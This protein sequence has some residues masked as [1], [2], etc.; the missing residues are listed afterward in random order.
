[1]F[2]QWRSRFRGVLLLAFF[3]GI[4]SPLAAQTISQQRPSPPRSELGLEIGVPRES[5]HHIRFAVS[6]G[7]R[8][9]TLIHRRSLSISD[10]QAAGDFTAIDVSAE[11]DGGAIRVRVSVIYNDLSNQ[12]WWK[13]KKEKIAGSYV[14]REGE[15]VWPTELAQ[16][17]IEPFEMK[18]ISAGPIVFKPGEGP[19]IIN[20]STALE[21][22]RLE[23]HLDS[24]LISLKNISSK[25]VVA[26]TISTGRGGGVSTSSGGRGDPVI[27]AGATTRET[28]LYGPNVELEGITISNVIFDDGTFEGD[29]NVAAHFLARAEG[30]RIQAP[31]VLLKIEQ[32]LAV[33]DNEFQAAFDRLEAELWVIPEAIDKQSALEFLQTKFPSLDEKTLSAL[34]EELKGGLYDARNIALS[35]MGVNRRNIQERQQRNGDDGSAVKSLRATLERVKQTLEKITSGQH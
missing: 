7:G 10:P 35:D 13:D 24:Y 14:V 4:A 21:V 30:V 33:D 32:T 17:G 16:F 15:P 18:V 19:R 28:H 11:G 5:M 34:Y 3:T 23:K 20:N 8:S 2:F 29:P 6:N 12:E 25:N 1:M 26:Y 22:A 9:S 27:A 31:H